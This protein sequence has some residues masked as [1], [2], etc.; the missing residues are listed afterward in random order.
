M[1][2]YSTVHPLYMA[3]FSKPLYRD[4]ARNWKGYC[5]TYL[6]IILSLYWIPEIVKLHLKASE[7]IDAEA[8]KYIKQVPTITVT[9]GVVTIKEAVPYIIRHPETGKPFIIIDTS[10]EFTSLRKSAAVALL[11]KT[12]LLISFDDDSSDAYVFD[13][14]GIDYLVVD[15]QTVYASI[16]L[17][18][19]WFAI[20]EFPIVLFFS[21]LYH[22]I[23]VFLCVSFGLLFAKKFD[24]DMKYAPLIRL[25]VISFTPA[26]ILQII[27]SLLD[28]EF[29]YKGIISFFISIAYLYFAVGAIAEE[30]T[31]RAEWTA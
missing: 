2:K 7:I 28:I 17:F 26:I 16:E 20:I 23:Q 4:V 30:S 27:H 13:L 31:G 29:P 14:A 21:F 22:I 11:T 19:Q 1:R 8:P 9:D 10:G 3:F 15:Q 24:L 12:R 5:L 18:K 25:A 6:L